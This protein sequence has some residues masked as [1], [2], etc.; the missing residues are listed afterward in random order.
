MLH[1]CYS[2]SSVKWTINNIVSAADLEI[3][4]ADALPAQV[5]GN[6]M[7]PQYSKLTPAPALAAIPADFAVVRI[8]TL[9]HFHIEEGSGRNMK[10]GRHGRLALPPLVG[11]ADVL[12]S[13]RRQ[14]LDQI[15]SIRKG[16]EFL[17]P[18]DGGGW[19][20]VKRNVIADT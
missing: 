11:S 13:I 14:R 15:V 10:T 17:L 7:R 16:P 4:I 6:T 3:R 19:V 20:G 9:N 5:M 8:K 18:L 2:S 12:T 1:F